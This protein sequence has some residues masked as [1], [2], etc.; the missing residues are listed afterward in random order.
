MPVALTRVVI[1]VERHVAAGGW[2]QPP[3]LFAL[4]ETTE[5]LRREP[6]LLPMIGSTDVPA[7]S[8]T[9]IEQDALPADR[10]LDEVIAGM[11]WPDEVVGCALV[12][13]RLVLPPTAEESMPEEDVQE[14]VEKHP[15]RQEMRIAVAVLRD[16]TRES[17]LRLRNHDSEEAVL[18][19]PDLVPHLA[20]ALA[21]TFE[22]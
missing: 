12:L 13:E 15:Q 20:K 3:R 9:P 6:G 11:V 18:S 19:G 14:W 17:A 7:G 2:D 8:L 1:E 5:L 21:V 4:A 22:S 10:A 16:G